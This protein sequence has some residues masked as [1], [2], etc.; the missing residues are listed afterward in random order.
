[1]SELSPAEIQIAAEVVH[2]FQATRQPT[3]RLPLLK[4]AKQ[5]DTLE[6]LSR[7]SILR[8]LDNNKYLPLA[9][10]FHYCG[11]A[12]ALAVAKLSVQLV[13]DVLKTMLENSDE[14]NKQ[15]LLLDI[16]QSARERY[17]SVEPDKIWLGLYLGDEFRLCSRWGAQPF[18]IRTVSINE[19]VIE[20]E[21]TDTLWDEFVKDRT[22]WIRGQLRGT[23]TASHYGFFPG[24]DEDRITTINSKKVFV[25][26]GHDDAINGSV[27]DFLQELG[28]DVII[29]QE[30]PNRGQTIVEKL[31]AHSGVGFAVVILTPDD[32]GFAAKE[33]DKARKRA[34]Q[35]VILEL[36]LFIGE[37]GRERVCPIYAND[38]ELPSDIH[39]LLYIR[40]DEEGKWRS[41]L[42]KEITAAGIETIS[43]ERSATGRTS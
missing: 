6:K 32:I 1:M 14:E 8:P 22:G 12:K 30:Q 20:I 23:P 11:D 21:S 16:E 31:E 36:G 9:L 13:A 25:V 4:I 43:P 33:P 42:L 37:L 19:H 26:H 40:Y 28:L 18:E 17:G 38:L 41:Q 10:A 27:A 24:E 5:L 29:L 3:P 7:W 15:Y 39:G 35:N 2:S 34:R